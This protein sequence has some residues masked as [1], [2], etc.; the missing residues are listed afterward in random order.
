VAAGLTKEGI[1]ALRGALARHVDRGDLAGLVSLVACGGD[2]DIET[3]GHKAFGDSEPI[4]RDTI[5]RIASST[6]C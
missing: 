5:F 3:I 2:T 4:G 6:V 1:E